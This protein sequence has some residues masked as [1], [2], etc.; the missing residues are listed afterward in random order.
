MNSRVILKM[1]QIDVP[2]IVLEL[3]PLIGG[4]WKLVRGCSQVF[5]DQNKLSRTLIRAIWLYVVFRLRTINPDWKCGEDGTLNMAWNSRDILKMAEIDVPGIVL[6]LIPL[7][8]GPWKLVRGC[9]QVFYDQNRLSRTLIWTIWLY[10]VFRLRTINPYWKCGEDGTLKGFHNNL[11]FHGLFR[12]RLS[13]QIHYCILII[14]LSNVFNVGFDS[15]L[16]NSRQ[17]VKYAAEPGPVIHVIRF[18]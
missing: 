2:G 17:A 1:A 14:Y 13:P 8:R 5:Y 10:V 9:S 4:P 6:E 12:W 3:I 7:I 18:E 15:D 16:L 11:W